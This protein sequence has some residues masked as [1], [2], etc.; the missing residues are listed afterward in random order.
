MYNSNSNFII[1]D[2]IKDIFRLKPKNN[3][4]NT[5]NNI[6]N[7]DIQTNRQFKLNNYL[8]INLEKTTK[9][10]EA[11]IF[12]PIYQTIRKDNKKVISTNN[13][14][15]K[16]RNIL[17]EKENDNNDNKIKNLYMSPNIKIRNKL[18]VKDK[19][20]MNLIDG[21]SID[22]SKQLKSSKSNKCFTENCKNFDNKNKKI[23]PIYQNILNSNKS[24]K[25]KY[26]SINN[27]IKNANRINEQKIV[28][29]LDLNKKLNE[30]NNNIS[31]K[32]ITVAKENNN[33]IKRKKLK[34]INVKVEESINANNNFKKILFQR[35]NNDNDKYKNKAMNKSVNM[36]KSKTI[37]NIKNIY[38][39]LNSSK[40]NILKTKSFRH[41]YSSIFSKNSLDILIKI[42]KKRRIK[43]WKDIKYRIFETK[44][45][46]NNIFNVQSISYNNFQIKNTFLKE[47]ILDDINQDNP[48]FLKKRINSK[49][50]IYTNGINEIFNYNENVN[51][52]ENSTKIKI[53]N[54]SENR[55]LKSKL[56]E[57]YLKYLF[58]K[59]NN[60]NKEVLLKSLYK[61]NKNTNIIN[62]NENRKKNLL[63]KIIEYKEQKEKNIIRK[64]FIK[65][66]FISKLTNQQR[67]FFCFKDFQDDFILMQKLYWI[68]YQKEKYN[69]L[70]L[71]KYFDKFRKNTIIINNKN[72]KYI[73]EFNHNII[74]NNKRNQ[75]LKLIII[76][77]SKHYNIII[78]NILQQWFLRCKIFKLNVG[79]NINNIRKKN[80]QQEDLIKGINKLN[81]IFNNYKD[82]NNTNYKENKNTVDINEQ[83]E[84]NI[85]NNELTNDL[86]EKDIYLKKLYIEKYK[87]DSIIEEKDEEQ[88]EE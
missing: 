7:N 58:E 83:K 36:L 42:F 51:K 39:N 3:R 47:Q 84:I 54:D 11:I 62:N 12:S 86:E 21:K 53:I 19:I 37:H 76:K 15:T 27:S 13:S 81:Y 52:C 30:T 20:C 75:K 68:I 34:N 29:E 64:F 55:E 46:N 24:C 70:S 60:R 65:F 28:Q 45:Y 59:K 18:I 4:L 85:I 63:K 10:P 32:N 22:N 49:N 8:T 56:K 77:I 88:T 17:L 57:T 48:T 5:Y 2:N 41:V 69:V 1:K 6:N 14:Q 40:E 25:G 66:H 38:R 9:E 82:D 43:I 33:K 67:Q 61:I 71:K 23:F 16:D 26:I 44:L 72:I 78:K 31:R 80:I 87:T 74:F 73:D 50:N 35:I 79:D